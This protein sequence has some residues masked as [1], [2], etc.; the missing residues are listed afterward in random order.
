M[1]EPTT[2]P[3]VTTPAPNAT[4]PETPKSFSVSESEWKKTQDTLGSLSSTISEQTE[5]INGAA[6]VINTLAYTPEL[7]EAFQAQLKK[8]YGMVDGGGQPSQQPPQT[9]AARPPAANASGSPGPDY[10][11]KVEEV[12]VAQREQ[13][14]SDFE[15]DFGIE[16]LKDEDKKGVRQKVESYLNEFGWSVKTMP[17]PKLRSA[18]EKAYWGANPDKLR[19]EGRFEGSAESRN[20]AY[21]RMP[22]IPGGAPPSSSQEPA[23]SNKQ[24]E[25]LKKLRV[26]EDAAK[27]RYLSRE[28]EYT[29]INPIEEEAQ[30]GR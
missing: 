14:I 28:E 11:R 12:S 2:T 30:K 15:K 16:G 29:R 8:Q 1:P 27:K 20:N 13:T 22:G 21:G 3:P 5:F 9:P 25:W 18:M 23:L 19:E 24:K 4:P 6:V 17:L 10:E 7:R 26:D